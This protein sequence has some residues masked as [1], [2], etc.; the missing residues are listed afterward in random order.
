MKRIELEA[1]K[2]CI[3]DALLDQRLLCHGCFVGRRKKSP[4]LSDKTSDNVEDFEINGKV[5][6][7]S[8]DKTI[9]LDVSSTPVTISYIRISSIPDVV[10]KSIKA[11]SDDLSRVEGLSRP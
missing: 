8:P 3:K 6:F 9:E 10:P 7:S 2:L 1:P 5:L 4:S 11:A